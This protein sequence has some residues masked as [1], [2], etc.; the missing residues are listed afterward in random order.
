M[1]PK[2]RASM[3]ASCIP[4]MDPY[5]LPCVNILSMMTS[6]EHQRNESEFCD[7]GVVLLAFVGV[8]GMHI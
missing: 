8:S 6:L 7:A 2:R 1:I 4:V 5:S 3:D